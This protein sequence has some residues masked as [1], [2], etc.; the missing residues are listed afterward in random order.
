MSSRE[1]KWKSL[2]FADMR[3]LT[4]GGTHHQ[5]RL[6]SRPRRHIHPCYTGEGRR[7][8]HWCTAML[9]REFEHELGIKKTSVSFAD[10]SYRE[11][12]RTGPEKQTCQL[13]FGLYLEGSG[14]SKDLWRG[15]LW[16]KC[17]STGSRPCVQE[18]A[19]KPSACRS[20]VIHSN[21]LYWKW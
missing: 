10:D 16:F 21:N 12:A 19:Q 1:V 14:A 9:V 7:K 18:A 11:A 17:S 15:L 2:T 3:V 20:R 13:R 4:N 6:A 8:V 5:H